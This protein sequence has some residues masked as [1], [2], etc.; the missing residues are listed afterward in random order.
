MSNRTRSRR[1]I[2]STIAS[3]ATL[4]LL[5]AA[6]TADPGDNGDSEELQTLQIALSA[7]PQPALVPLVFGV[8]NHG[9][10]VGLDLSV[11]NNVTIFDSHTTAAQTV[12][13]GRAEVLGSSISSILSARE[14]GEDFKIFCPYVSMDDFVLTGANG[15]TT[16]DQLFDPSTRVAI[17][18]PGGAGAII[19][20]AI[21]MGVGETRSIQELPNV[22]IIESSGLRTSAWAANQVDSTV[23]HEDQFTQAAGE[24]NEPVRIATLYENVDSFIKEAQ[25][26]EAGWLEENRELAA[27]YCATT[28]IAM[29]EL[30][31]DFDLFLEAVDT[32]VEEPPSEE[33]LSILFDLIEQYTFWTADGGLTPEDI[34]F[35]IEVATESGVLT[36]P[37]DGADVLDQETL[38]RAVEIANSVLNG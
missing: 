16:V 12:L 33:E 17:D 6:C 21:L 37:M 20:N 10:D 15:V 32:Y 19:L 14:Q 18:S 27:S 22:Q 28:L 3:A 24:V 25:A 35:M 38:D 30:K 26:A 2:A 1:A 13:G 29:A 8:D 34:D 5:L 11:E 31:A 23:I 9:A 36:E 4:T 7:Q